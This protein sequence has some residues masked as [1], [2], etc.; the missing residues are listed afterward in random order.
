MAEPPVPES[1]SPKP[2]VVA[3]DL[4]R[5]GP[6]R[7][8]RRIGAGG[9][10]AVY[11][12]RKEGSK[13]PLALK[14]LPREKA[15]NPTLVKRFQAEAQSAAQIR[16]PNVVEVVDSGEAD[17]YL[18]IAMEYVD[19]T[20]LHDFVRKRGP[21]PV[22]R[23]IEIVKQVASALQHAYEQNI[24]HRDI[25]PSNLLLRRDGQVKLSDFGLARSVDE[26]SES[27]IT[28]AGTTVGTVDFM[29]PEQARNSKSADVRSDLYSLGCAWYHML[30]GHA[31]FPD[32]GLTN[33]LQAHAIQAPPDPRTENPAV[34]DGL[35]AI[36]HRLMAKKPADR[37]Q[38]P[39]ELLDDLEAPGLT[40]QGVERNILSAV[41]EDLP[42]DQ[43]IILDDDDEDIGDL[44]FD[45]REEMAPDQK[46]KSTKA[47]RI[48]RSRRDGPEEPE[49]EE[50]EADAPEAISRR[51]RKKPSKNKP[52]RRESVEII[53]SD[54]VEEV[55]EV[56]APE[57]APVKRRRKRPAAEDESAENE[58][59][60]GRKSEKAASR[61]GG[62]ATTEDESKDKPKKKEKRRKLSDVA[63]AP[64]SSLNWEPLRN[65]SLLILGLV[66]VVGL[67]SLAAGFA[68]RYFGGG[69]RTLQQLRESNEPTGPS[70]IHG[71]T[72][73]GDG[74]GES[75]DEATG[76]TAAE[77]AMSTTNSAAATR[78]ERPP[79]RDPLADPDWL[80]QSSA[81]NVKVIRVGRHQPATSLAEG[82]DQAKGA[83]VLELVGSGVFFLPT[84]ELENRRLQMRPTDG[85]DHP[86]VVW[87]PSARGATALTLRGGLIEM[88]GLHLVIDLSAEAAD[89]ETNGP[90]TR[91]AAVEDGQFLMRK[92][93]LTCVG[94]SPVT[95]IAV[96][97]PTRNVLVSA[98]QQQVGFDRCI[99]RGDRLTPVMLGTSTADVTFHQCLSVLSEGPLAAVEPQGTTGSEAAS[100]NSPPGSL[101]RVLNTTAWGNRSLLRIQATEEPLPA[102]MTVGLRDS[103]I[104]TASPDQGRLIDGAWPS[105]GGSVEQGRLRDFRL[106]IRDSAILGLTNL[107]NLAGQSTPVS[108]SASLARFFGA[109]ARSIEQ[110]SEPWRTVQADSW[111][112]LTVAAFDP[113]TLPPLVTR[114]RAGR[115]PGSVIAELDWP[116]ELSP[117]RLAALAQRPDP[118]AATVPP[119]PGTPLVV[120]LNKQDLGL[121]IERDK[122]PD[123]TMIVATGSGRC[124][125]SPFRV[126]GRS[127]RIRFEQGNGPPLNLVPKTIGRAR[128]QWIMLAEQGGLHLEGASL[129]LDQAAA[130]AGIQTVFSVV[131]SQLRLDRCRLLDANPNPAE[132]AVLVDWVGTTNG[133][134]FTV[135]QSSLQGAGIALRAAGSRGRIALDNVLLAGGRAAMQVAPQAADG[136]CSID[137]DWN[138]VTAAS[139]GPAVD[140]RL[141]AEDVAWNRKLRMFVENSAFLASSV[142]GEKSEQ[143]CVAAA[144]P[145][146][147]AAKCVE[148]LGRSNGFASNLGGWFRG[149]T[150]GSPP[151]EQWAA[152]WGRDAEVRLLSTPDGIAVAGATIRGEA[153]DPARFELLPGCRGASWGDGGTPLGILPG[154]LA[155]NPTLRPARTS[156]PAPV[157]KP[158]TPGAKPKV[159]SF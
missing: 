126:A 108:D 55:E 81:S 122:L 70:T 158:G 142:A 146:P 154:Q 113:A 100:K 89:G 51:V 22:R 48:L 29:S 77:A 27:D 71:A 68:S 94:N 37:Y 52:P 58:D 18:Y 99:L 115:L 56:E 7:I 36:L 147:N 117:R 136:G 20:D 159:P 59:H 49:V 118:P 61:K 125:I 4:Q 107:V 32:G 19:G 65:V 93:S 149:E 84:L 34:T 35:V 39:K 64:R 53:D 92:C 124:Q 145:P 133:A 45:T 14:V 156:V 40:R 28:R 88:T 63:D 69:Q 116:N 140:F 9:M 42:S 3:Q 23:T 67:G 30:T 87:R 13:Q 25:K 75:T 155:A 103:L 82:I 83:S 79:V 91:L 78:E 129:Q 1:P 73:T 5:L 102:A 50:D 72:V 41:L 17:G 97:P 105:Q 135:I 104:A 150:T 137:V 121:M 24:V 112:K 96:V 106:H 127:L 33:K 152:L 57:D 110:L 130:R 151:G 86:V 80:T 114:T 46:P 31:P 43:Q 85:N 144:E 141:P 123:N 44:D 12:V 148:W 11:L 111:T 119:Q 157:Q 95:G 90:P 138:H 139:N 120:D 66:V 143:S 153:D 109:N 6:F 60:D 128:P 2:A 47:Q 101:L 16:H 15:K 10:G 26:A 131:D 74:V 62:T 132:D 134:A 38:T 54:V 76:E 8:E 21:I 98:S